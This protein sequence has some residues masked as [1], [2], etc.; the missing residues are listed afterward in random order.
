MFPLVFGNAIQQGPEVTSLLQGQ[1]RDSRGNPITNAIIDLGAVQ[2]LWQDYYLARTIASTDINGVK[3]VQFQI[4]EQD[5]AQGNIVI[6]VMDENKEL[7][8]LGG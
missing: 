8:H 7:A 5:I 1:F 2:I 4:L 3:Y 6:A